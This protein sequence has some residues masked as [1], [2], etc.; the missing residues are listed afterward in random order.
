V[1][2]RDSAVKINNGTS[3]LERF[4]NKN[5]FIY[6]CKKRSSLPMYVAV[7]YE[8]EGSAT[9]LPALNLQLQRLRYM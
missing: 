7:N 3:S 4:E 8:V 5:I 9:R 6:I 1:S 2:Y